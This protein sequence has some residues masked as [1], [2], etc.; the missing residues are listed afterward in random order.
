MDVDNDS[1]AIQ[2]LL[3]RVPYKTQSISFRSI[4]ETAKLEDIE[5]VS[6]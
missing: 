3:K 6:F 1:S 5:N 4:P 2:E